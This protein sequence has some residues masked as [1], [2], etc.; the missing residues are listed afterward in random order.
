VFKEL[1]L[2][3]YK[4]E[5]FYWELGPGPIFRSR[6]TLY[7]CEVWGEFFRLRRRLRRILR[8][9]TRRRRNLSRFWSDLTLYCTKGDSPELVSKKKRV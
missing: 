6:K 7:W 2:F 8:S 4:I 1:K 9:F 3:F 5:N